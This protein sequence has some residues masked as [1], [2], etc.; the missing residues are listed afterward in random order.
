MSDIHDTSSVQAPTEAD[1][2]GPLRKAPLSLEAVA[3]FER[4]LD[5][6]DQRSQQ[7]RAS[8]DEQRQ[9]RSED[10]GFTLPPWAVSVMASGGPA[11]MVPEPTGSAWGEVA[12]C[13][14]RLLVSDAT[15]R[16]EGAA[17]LFRVAPGLLE[18]TT[19]ALSRTESGWLLRIDTCD[20]RLRA[21]PARHEAAL[22]ERFAR[23]G[24][25][26]LTIEQGELPVLPL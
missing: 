5:Q 1:L 23:Q 25:G 6:A 18:D 17:A 21:D 7:Q 22:R 20:A 2:A 9:E 26:E 16:A 24:L 11:P 3:A 14:E 10:P 15:H 8:A 19:L 13:I 4:F 12:A